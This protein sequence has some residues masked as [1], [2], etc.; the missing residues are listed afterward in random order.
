MSFENNLPDI[1]GNYYELQQ[2]IINLLVNAEYFMGEAHHGG[3]LV[4]TTRIINDTL[5]ISFADDGPGISP[6]NMRLFSTRFSLP[7]R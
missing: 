6:D 2:V 5:Q 3:R 4:I 7:S 1:M